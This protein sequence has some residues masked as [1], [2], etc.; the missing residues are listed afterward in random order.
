MQCPSLEEL[1]SLLADGEGTEALPGI[2]DHV[3]NCQ[4]CLQELD[5]LSDDPELVA[6]RQSMQKALRLSA[7]EGEAACQQLVA[8]L[9]SL[10]S[11]LD[12]VVAS[13]DTVVTSELGLLPSEFSEDLGTLGPYR[14][15]REL[16]RGGMSLVFEALDT[17][18][19][20]S[21]A[22][23]ILRPDRVD[24]ESRERFM[25]ES[26]ALANVQ[27]RNVISIYD[28]AASESGIPYFVTEL[29]RAGTLQD[30]IRTGIVDARSAANCIASVA[31]G[32]SAAHQAGLIHRD[33]KPSNILLSNTGENSNSTTVEAAAPVAS[34]ST[35][36][37]EA[38]QA[39]DAIELKRLVP[40]LAD[41]GLARSLNADIQLTQTQALF[42]TPAYMS[43]EQIIAPKQ[44]TAATDIYS[45]GVTLY[46]LLTGEIPY[47]G[48]TQAVLQQ[49]VE[50][51]PPAL[52][53]LNRAI[54][55]DIE[56]ICL[57]AMHVDP[58]RRYPTVV[59]FAEDLRRFLRSE[60]I[61]ARPATQLE[62]AW[63]WSVRRPVQAL[64]LGAIIGLLLCLGAGA[65]ASSLWL[66]RA[67]HQA[68][69]DAERIES[70]R[71]QAE[72]AEATAD[73]QR[74]LALDVLSDLVRKVQQELAS[75]PA[76]FA[77]RQSL[78]TTAFDGLQRIA[79]KTE[80]DR[81][82]HIA[83]DALLQ[84]SAIQ[85]TLGN[86][87]EAR[88]W[89]ERGLELA[90]AAHLQEP[91]DVEN[92]RDL[93]N[94]LTSKGHYYRETFTYEEAELLFNRSLLLRDEIVAAMPGDPPSLYAQLANRQVLLDLAIYKGDFA[95]AEIGLGELT[96]D[97]AELQRQF[98]DEDAFL[99][100]QLVSNNRLAM[101]LATKREYAEAENC[102]HIAKDASE[103]LVERDRESVVYQ[104][105]LASVLVRLARMKLLQGE[106]LLGIPLAVQAREI[107]SELAT[108]SPED[109]NARSLV[110]SNWHLQ[111]ELNLAAEQLASAL[112]A[113]EQ[114]LDIQKELA[115]KFPD[116]SRYA[117]LAAEAAFAASD[118]NFRM[119]TISAAEFAAEEAIAFLER[120][121]RAADYTPSTGAPA[122]LQAYGSFQKSC[123]TDVARKVINALYSVEWM[124]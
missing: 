38:E 94:A 95:T 107:H 66:N 31:D 81:A 113:V 93:A 44:L 56:T 104:G 74:E 43:P 58:Q 57:R 103:Q 120:A 102:L 68:K 53:R 71:R 108:A 13:R 59:A 117:L 1:Q 89:L 76:T 63:R 97:V 90:E 48:S 34:R 79:K 4:H 15:L 55:A 32:L 92:V 86:R 115:D 78:L 52:R 122:I 51:D 8:K 47:R 41:F 69:L 101:V 72:Q 75:R 49:I 14:I 106:P 105:D 111:Y 36:E 9:R 116:T 12:T 42:G 23:K 11:A 87:I 30:R 20:R 39:G 110:G 10:E 83:V 121:Q 109:V 119:G 26:R 27:H 7:V 84:M 54:P 124:E 45:L 67:Y 118:V 85:N 50:G 77:L 2:A 21:V 64:Q 29:M 24:A 62:K 114:G 16:G 65:T 28:V 88:E 96:K 70:E 25:R 123:N 6:I 99:R 61:T 17:R 80:S 5:S 19:Q 73:Q 112:A 91:N 82:T 37:K 98:P 3:A 22:I 35:E 46:E 33:I 100:G 60:P 18:L 40:R